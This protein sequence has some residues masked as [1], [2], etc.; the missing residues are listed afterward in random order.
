MEE[1]KKPGILFRHGVDRKLL[2]W[3]VRVIGDCIKGLKNIRQYRGRWHLEK[4][5][6]HKVHFFHKLA[7]IQLAGE[8]NKNTLGSTAR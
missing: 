6:T 7:W 2:M 8:Y 1:E 5:Q 4:P 3:P